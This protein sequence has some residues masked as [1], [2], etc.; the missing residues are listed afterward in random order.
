MN[1]VTR[2]P[3]WV[4]NGQLLTTGNLIFI[5]HGASAQSEARISTRK[6]KRRNSRHQGDFFVV[7]D[8][9]RPQFMAGWKGCLRAGRFPFVPVVLTLSACHPFG[10]APAVTDSLYK[11]SLSFMTAYRCAVLRDNGPR[12]SALSVARHLTLTTTSYRQA[13]KMATR[14]NAVIVASHAV[15]GAVA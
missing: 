3:Q 10:L 9:P 14:L 11:R 4:A 12:L 5:V 2:L 7:A 1:A 15:K 8:T 6:H 13:M